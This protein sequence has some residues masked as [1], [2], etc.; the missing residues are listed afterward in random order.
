MTIVCFDKHRKD[1]KV[2]A[3]R[4]EGRWHE[5]QEI[6]LLAPMKSVYRPLSCQPVFYF[7]A[8]FPVRI[9]ATKGNPGVITVLPAEWPKL[10]GERRVR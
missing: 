10:E 4:H 2:A 6:R 7:E 1:R 9:C 5:A 3:V 8:M